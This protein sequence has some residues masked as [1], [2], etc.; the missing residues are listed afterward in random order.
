VT[1]TVTMKASATDNVKVSSVS[2]YLDGRLRCSS[3][4]SVSCSWNT[5]YSSRGTHTI[6]ATAKDSAGNTATTSVSVTKK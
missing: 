6:S 2:L 3:T 1:G 4:S 5:R